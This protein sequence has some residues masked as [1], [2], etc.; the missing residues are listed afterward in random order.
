MPA[1]LPTL[2][3]QDYPGSFTVVLVDDNS[4]DDTLRVGQRV[5]Q[6]LGLADRLTAL[7]GEPTP[8][9]WAGK[10]WAMAQGVRTAPRCSFYLLTDADIAHPPDSLRCLVSLALEKDLDLASIMVLLRREGFWESLL[11]PPFV[12]FFAMLYPFQWVSSPRGRIS[13]AA[14]GCMLVRREALEKVGGL[15]AIASAII[16]D[17]AL[18]RAIKK[19]GR[20][21]GGRLWLGYSYRHKSLRQYG[22]LAG[23]WKMVSRSAYAQ[24]RYNPLWLV[25]TVGA[26]GIAYWG[27]WSLIAM[28]LLI[29]RPLAPALGMAAYA[30]MALCYYPMVRWY[31]LAAWWSLALPLAAL[32][33]ALMTIDSAV[34]HWRQRPVLWR[35]RLPPR[36]NS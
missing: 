7:L 11:V 29:H 24:L 9:G 5:A 8:Q 4:Q 3:Q 15:E 10:V 33:Y 32:L 28:G 14:G 2:L 17:L 13:A 6:R 25:L 34:A 35:G 20:D 30:I 19:G 23:V 16:D 21:Q 26:M 27:P 12:H 1:T 22:G 18:A 36:P 31:R